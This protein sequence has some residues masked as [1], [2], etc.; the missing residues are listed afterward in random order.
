MLRGCRIW[1]RRTWPYSNVEPAG[2]PRSFRRVRCCAGLGWN[3]PTRFST[4]NGGCGAGCAT[5]GIRPWGRSIGRRGA[6]P[7]SRAAHLAIGAQQ[8]TSVFAIVARSAVDLADPDFDR[9]STVLFLDAMVALEAKPL[10]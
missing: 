10:P 9:Y 1:G 3:R 4:W 7:I 5:P 6:E 8:H 2:T